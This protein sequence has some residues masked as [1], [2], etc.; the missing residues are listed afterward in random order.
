MN[1]QLGTNNQY[2]YNFHDQSLVYPMQAISSCS[3]SDG[4]SCNQISYGN[5]EIMCQI[6]FEETQKFTLDSY[7]TTWADHQKA[8]GYFG[9]N[10]QSSQLQYDDHTNIE[11]IKELISSSSSNG[12][13]CN[14]V[15]YWG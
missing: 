14:N 4:L 11:E 8:N 5:E 9:N 15:G 13:G 10:F 1:F 12:N 3:S 6:P 2:S 7:C